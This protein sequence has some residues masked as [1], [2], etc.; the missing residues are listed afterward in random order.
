MSQ[1]ITSQYQISTPPAP[2]QNQSFFA[3]KLDTSKTAPQNASAVAKRKI[4]LPECKWAV[5]YPEVQRA[6]YFANVCTVTA[7]I[8]CKYYDIKPI[9]QVGP[10]CGLTAL[11]MIFDGIPSAE[12]LLIYAKN[13]NYTNNGEMFSA[14]NLLC[15][16]LDF[17]KKLDNDKNEEN[18]VRAFIFDGNMNDAILKDLIRRQSALVLFA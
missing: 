10:T 12:E 7:P 16:F 18:A 2:P 3:L 8:Y 4:E 15:I 14:E 9:T 6:F 17:I 11:S 13:R 5:T 1:T